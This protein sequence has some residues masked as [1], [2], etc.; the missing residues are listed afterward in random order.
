MKFTK[1]DWDTIFKN[2]DKTYLAP[3]NI[4]A[5]CLNKNIKTIADIGGGNGEFASHL[6]KLGYKLDLYDW[7]VEA[8]SRASL[9]LAGTDVGMHQLDFNTSSL[10]KM[11]DVTIMNSSLAFIQNKEFFL[12]NVRTH[13]RYFV[14]IWSVFVDKKCKDT[15]EHDISIGLDTEEIM[16][17]LY[18][19]FSEVTI[20]FEKKRS[21]HSSLRLLKC[22]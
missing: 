11:Y 14:L 12:K 7:S 6:Y 8:L 10:P 5:H 22:R 2:S 16:S 4:I 18:K 9:R 1:T 19:I 15:D 13:T 20:I 3:K 17:L 21:K